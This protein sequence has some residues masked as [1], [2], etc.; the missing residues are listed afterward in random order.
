MLENYFLVTVIIPTY[1][2]AHYIQQAIDSVLNSDFFQDEIEIIVIDDGSQDSTSEVVAAYGNQVKYIYQENSGKA[3]STKVG[4]ENCQG[5]YIF[6]LDADDLFLPNKIREVV[7]IFE[8]DPEIVHVAHPAI[9]WQVDVNKQLPEAIP[10]KIIANKLDGKELLIYFYRNRMLF[11]GGSTFAARKDY[12]KTISIPKEIDMYIDE[13][14]VMSILNQGYSYFIDSPLSIWRIHDNNYSG[15]T[16]NANNY[17]SKMVRSLK[18]IDGILNNLDAFDPEIRKLYTLKYKISE[19]ADKERIGDKKI[20]DV[21]SM[22]SFFLKNF[23]I[24]NFHSCTVIKSYTLINRTL[25]IFMLN[26]LRFI[27]NRKA[28]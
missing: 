26:L 24:F 28:Q 23:N 8:S 25:P 4:I 10:K 20:S 17:Q 12:L 7:Q 2:Y 11:G 6:N 14:L 18:S 21:L 19:I 13:Y 5:K 27:K 22:W 16:S 1:N 3:W 9:C 15:N